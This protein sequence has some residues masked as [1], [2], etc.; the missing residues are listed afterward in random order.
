V[1]VA[2]HPD[3]GINPGVVKMVTEIPPL[4]VEFK[5]KPG[6]K[7]WGDGDPIGPDIHVVNP[8]P[9]LRFISEDANIRQVIGATGEVRFGDTLIGPQGAVTGER[10]KI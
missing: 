9:A 5:P 4:V 8:D 3:F 2:E 7:F 10:N 1:H 6:P